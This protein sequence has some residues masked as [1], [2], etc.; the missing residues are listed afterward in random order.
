WLDIMVSG[1]PYSKARLVLKN[2][3]LFCDNR[4][5]TIVA[6]YGQGV[7]HGVGIANGERLCSISYLWRSVF[8]RAGANF[9]D[10]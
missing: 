9:Q 7:H 2:L 10:R 4:P 6:I 1:G 8:E 5:G 3:G